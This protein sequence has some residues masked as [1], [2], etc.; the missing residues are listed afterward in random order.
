MTTQG[1]IFQLEKIVVFLKQKPYDLY[2]KYA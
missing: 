2:N 1:G